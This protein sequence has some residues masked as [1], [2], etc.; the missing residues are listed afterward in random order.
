MKLFQSVQRFYGILGIVPTQY[1]QRCSINWR[2]VLA[3]LSLGQL[4]ISTLAFCLF[5]AKSIKEYADSYFTCMTGL[6]CIIHFL[7]LANKIHKTSAL[8]E[9][10]DKLIEDGR[11][12]MQWRSWGIWPFFFFLSVELRNIDTKQIFTELDERIEKVSKLAYTALVKVTMTG[13]VFPA[14]VITGVAYFT[15]DSHDVTFRLAYPAMYVMICSSFQRFGC[16]S[17]VKDFQ[18]IH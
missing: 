13:T 12:W 7:V 2:N 18:S 14:Y 9:H 5:R 15:S 11:F 17:K 1:N 16:K 8:I 6:D 10:Y 4:F 3:L